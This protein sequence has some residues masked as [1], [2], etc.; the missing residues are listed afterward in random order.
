MTREQFNVSVLV[1]CFLTHASE[2]S[3]FRTTKHNAD[4]DGVKYSSH[5]FGFGKDVVY[6]TPLP[7]SERAETAERLGLLLVIEP[8]HDH[9]QPIGWRAG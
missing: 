3:G 5:R 6:D 2:T 1:Y 8:D 4:V 7:A 9:L